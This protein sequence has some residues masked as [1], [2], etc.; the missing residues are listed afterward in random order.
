MAEAGEGLLVRPAEVFALAAR[1]RDEAELPGATVPA[2][3]TEAAAETG[4]P[5]LAE[6][7]ETV[8][9]VVAELAVWFGDQW[10]RGGDV[11]TAGA[12]QTD[13]VDRGLAEG[14]S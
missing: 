4:A 2:G 5:T 3:G 10:Q 1:L 14:S 12:A 8:L 9:G 7:V 13:L 11:I 6:A